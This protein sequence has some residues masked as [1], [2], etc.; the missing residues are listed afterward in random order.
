MK[1]RDA[2]PGDKLILI[3]ERD[4]CILVPRDRG[5]SGFIEVNVGQGVV[6]EVEYTTREWKWF[7]FPVKIRMIEEAT[8]FYEDKE[9]RP[10]IWLTEDRKRV[11]IT[12][13]ETGTLFRVTKHRRTFEC[14]ENVFDGILWRFA[15]NPPIS[16]IEIEISEEKQ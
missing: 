16:K 15:D 4:H 1:K 6:T 12:D 10:E 3:K 11:H 7:I 2:V 5:N 8:F 14:I 9:S 13:F